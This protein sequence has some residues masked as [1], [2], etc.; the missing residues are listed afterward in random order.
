MKKINLFLLILLGCFITPAFA[1][2]DLFGLTGGTDEVSK[3][4]V[5]YWNPYATNITGTVLQVF[6]NK[7]MLVGGIILAYTLIVGTMSTAHDGEMLGKKWSSAWLPIRTAIAPTLLLPVT[8]GGYNCVQAIIL[9]LAL[10]GNQWGNET[11]NALAPSLITDSTYIS[12]DNKILI[13]QNVMNT[14]YSAAC[15]NV[16]NRYAKKANDASRWGQLYTLMSG[17][18]FSTDE[19]VGYRFGIPGD[20]DPSLGGGIDLC[21]SSVLKL[22]DEKNFKS[23]N[24][25]IDTGKIA[26]AVQEAQIKAN[27]I[28]VLGAKQYADYLVDAPLQNAEA[29]NKQIDLMVNAYSAYVQASAEKVMKDALSQDE[30]DR[31]TEKGWTYSYTYYARIANAISDANAAVNRYP[32]STMNYRGDEDVYFNQQFP[33]SS[34]A[35]LKRLQTLLATANKY[36]S[37]MKDSSK[38]D[39]G[40]YQKVISTIG[41]NMAIINS[42]DESKTSSLMPL[43]VS[44][45]IGSRMILSAEAAYILVTG[46]AVAGGSIP[47]VGDGIQ[48]AAIILSPMLNKILS[49][50]INVGDVLTFVNPMLPYMIG[51]FCVGAYYIL[52]FEALA[53]STLLAAA[54][55]FP[56]QDG[57]VGKQGQGYM[58]ALSVLLRPTMNMIGLA[59]S[60]VITTIM[61]D[62]LNSTFFTAASNTEGGLLGINKFLTMIII[63]TSVMITM[64]VMCLKLLYIIPDTIFKWIGGASSAVLGM[65]SGQTESAM[66]KGIGAAAIGSGVLANLMQHKHQ[67]P[68]NSGNNN[69][70]TGNNVP[71]ATQGRNEESSSNTDTTQ[72]TPQDNSKGDSGQDI[73]DFDID[74]K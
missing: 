25:I 44:V 62:L 46:G 26:K 23:E 59:G 64:Q 1:G 24:A 42:Q 68:K 3:N 45:N 34:L 14:L 50:M 19:L 33:P 54:L 18:R 74:K 5:K 28:L 70:L 57:V 22:I 60:Y 31:M 30:V 51:F 48:T 73:N 29:I 47:F 58:L 32:T 8:T 20:G 49:T 38:S 11:W 36:N 52:I 13:R 2:V 55:L 6:S 12:V 69:D 16:Y 72:N 7:V 67:Q 37:S 35:T 4:V 41:G 15:V 65:V 56:D 63:Y 27:D 17:T 43:T 53:G 66:S 21:G 61:F 9:W 40:A 71:K 39:D 10:Q